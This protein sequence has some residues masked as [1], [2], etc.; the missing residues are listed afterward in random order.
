MSFD[1]VAKGVRSTTPSNTG[2]GQEL[3]VSSLS[4]RVWTLVQT[5]ISIESLS[6]GIGGPSDTTALRQRIQSAENTGIALQQ[7]IENGLKRLR[8]GVMSGADHTVQ[9]QMKRLEDQYGEVKER[10]IKA[11][12]DSRSKRRQFTPQQVQQGGGAGAA[13][14]SSSSAAGGPR[15][16]GA[17]GGGHAGSAGLASIDIQLQQ[18]T[19]VDAAIAEVSN[20]LLWGR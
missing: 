17:K 15:G 2:N 3:T 5:C 12:Q 19:E 13:G 7:E 16:V 18:L 4:Q 10:F 6:G 9:R 8:I 1:A 20:Y 11:V 14:S